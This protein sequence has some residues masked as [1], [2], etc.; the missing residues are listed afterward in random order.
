MSEPTLSL[1]YEGFRLAVADYLGY[2]IGSSS[3]TAGQLFRIE[4]SVQSGYRLFLYPDTGYEWSFLR[5]LAQLVTVAGEGD[6]DAPDDFAGING[7]MTYGPDEIFQPIVVVNEARIREL[8]MASAASTVQTGR[9]F[10]VGMRPKKGTGTTGQRQL[11]TFHPMPDAEYTISYRYNALQGEMSAGLPYPLGGG[12]H[13]ETVKQS[14]LAY[15]EAKYNDE[16]RQ[17][18]ALFQQRMESSIKMDG[19][20]NKAETL[21]TITDG[22]DSRGLI[23]RQHRLSRSITVNG[24][25]I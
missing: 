20:L 2:G 5:P 6:Y 25:P 24:T 10:F 15:A 3:W 12:A 18:R 7:P 22:S 11:F 23:P 1:E 9:P 4:E 8:R 19:Q 13:G 21:G 17:H 16:V 14:I